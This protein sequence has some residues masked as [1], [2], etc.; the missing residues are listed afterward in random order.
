MTKP[1]QTQINEVVIP[2]LSEDKFT[3]G[4]EEFQVK[5]L[6]IV[7]EK[8]FIRA[9]TELIEKLDLSSDN[10]M[11]TILTK[12]ISGKLDSITD[13]LIDLVLIICQHQKSNITREYIANNG[14]SK[15][16]FNIVLSQLK[17]QELLDLIVGFIQGALG[18]VNPPVSPTS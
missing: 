8:R 9:V 1:T 2:E 3:I 5:L 6:P 16:L 7:V 11:L 15:Q 17:K 12:D 18:K 4:N 10:S 13:L 14:Y